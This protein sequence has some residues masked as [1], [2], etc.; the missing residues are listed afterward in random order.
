MRKKGQR[1]VS[2]RINQK[3]YVRKISFDYKRRAEK[4]V[5]HEPKRAFRHPLGIKVLVGYLFVLLGFYL[6]YLFLGIKSPIAI[7]FGQVIGGLPALSLVAFMIIVTVVLIFGLLKM[8]KWGYYFALAWFAFGIA[9][10]LVSLVLLKSEVISFTRSFLI[11]SS[12]TI[13]VIDILA[14]LYIA[15]EKNY[16]FARQFLDKRTRVVDKVFVTALVA[17]LIVTISIGSSMGY[18]FYKTNLDQADSIIQELQAKAPEEQLAVCSEK[19]D[20]QKDLC[21]LIVSIK[22]ASKDLCSQIQSDFYRF[23]CMSS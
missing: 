8:K 14:I 15:S 3:E 12:I 5:F 20:P 22:T 11:L 23:S 13:F 1:A 17:F 10:S 19:Q 2:K 4:A 18:N 21:I 7:V 9:N 16:F 6:F